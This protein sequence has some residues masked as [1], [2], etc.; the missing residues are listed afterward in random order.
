ML[1]RLTQ[2][3]YSSKPAPEFKLKRFWKTA[4]F[5]ERNDGFAVLLDT[6]E[7]KTPCGLPVRIPAEKRIL[8]KYTADEWNSQLNVLKAHSLPITSVVM[9]SLDSFKDQ[10][11]R[12][13]VVE[14]LLKYVHTDSICYQQDYPSS[15]VELQEKYW[16][17]IIEWIEEEYGL[18]INTTTGIYRAHYRDLEGFSAGKGYPKI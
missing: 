14:S 15:F 9:R 13:K 18:D 17:P 4:S 11:E 1:S 16:K 5:A 10:N 7:L 12:Q 2:R 6:K 3:L 8:A